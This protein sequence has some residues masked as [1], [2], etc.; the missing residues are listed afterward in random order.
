MARPRSVWHLA[1]HWHLPHLNWWMQEWYHLSRV[2]PHGQWYH[3]HTLHFHFHPFQCCQRLPCCHFVPMSWHFSVLVAQLWEDSFAASMNVFQLSLV[4]H[5]CCSSNAASARGGLS[6]CLVLEDVSFV[7]SPPHITVLIWV[8]FCLSFV[9][10]L[11]TSTSFMKK[12]IL[13]HFKVLLKYFTFLPIF[14]PLRMAPLE[15]H[16]FCMLPPPFTHQH[17]LTS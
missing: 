5:S 6:T 13:C 1:Y 15:S 3:C 11:N 10:L 7:T 9:F 2:L 4:N 8:T 12:L 16:F 14:F 17:P